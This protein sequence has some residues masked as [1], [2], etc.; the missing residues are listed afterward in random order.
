M[1]RV[2]LDTHVWTWTFVETGRMSAAA[3]EAIEAADDVFLSAVAFFEIGQKVR[4]GKWDD[5]AGHAARLAEIA[6]R[7]RISVVAVDG[8][9]AASAGLLDW[10]HRDPFDRLIAA[11]A[12][13]LNMP[14]VTR[15]PA[16]SDLGQLTRIW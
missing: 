10:P 5:L 16:F 1:S 2:L 7:Q 15:D 9:I 6:D 3:I 8:R 11:T 4:L 13:T 12:L 14:L